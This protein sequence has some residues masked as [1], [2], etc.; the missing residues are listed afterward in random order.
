MIPPSL[1]AEIK[2]SFTC[3]QFNNTMKKVINT[4]LHVNNRGFKQL[5][6]IYMVCKRQNWG[7]NS[8]LSDSRGALH[9][10]VRYNAHQ[11]PHTQTRMCSYVANF[12]LVH[13]GKN[14]FVFSNQNLNNFKNTVC[15]CEEANCKHR[16]GLMITFMSEIP[17]KSL[18]P[19]LLVPH[20]YLLALIWRYPLI[21]NEHEAQNF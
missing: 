1:F 14:S 2:I 21:C 10:P 6:Y 7:L 12:V 9:L 20:L 3:F 4:T 19:Q 11:H 18:H 15:V 8:G 5:T 16:H 13:L 17:E